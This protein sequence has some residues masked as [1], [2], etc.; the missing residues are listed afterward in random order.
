MPERSILDPIIFNILINDLYLPLKK[1]EPHNF[2]DLNTIASAD[3]TVGDLKEKFERHS[4]TAVDWFK[5][6]EMILNLD[7]FEDCKKK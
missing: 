5:S 1:S 6:N 7:K 4:K 3:D 2:A